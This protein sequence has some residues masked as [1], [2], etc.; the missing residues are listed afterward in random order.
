MLHAARR[1]AKAS[2]ISAGSR[3]WFLWT[4]LGLVSIHFT[5]VMFA[6]A[7][8]PYKIFGKRCKRVAVEVYGIIYI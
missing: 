2:I 7:N 4:S 8:G 5:R 3:S 1:I 6:R